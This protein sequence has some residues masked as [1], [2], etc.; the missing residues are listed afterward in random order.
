MSIV[1]KYTENWTSEGKIT[2]IRVNNPM[3]ED[4]SIPYKEGAGI[5]EQLILIKA[6]GFIVLPYA[7]ACYV[8]LE[9]GKKISYAKDSK[10][11]L[12]KPFII[13]EAEAICQDLTEVVSVPTIKSEQVQKVENMKKMNDD[14]EESLGELGTQDVPEAEDVPKQPETQDVPDV[15][16]LTHEQI[17]AMDYTGLLTKCKETGHIGRTPK[18]KDCVSYLKTLY[19]KAV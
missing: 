1:K 11:G 9:L 5:P 2:P 18:K 10:H 12:Q 14:Y 19:P 15:N 6:G 16:A 4:F 17:D 7:I 13:K 8:A 3:K